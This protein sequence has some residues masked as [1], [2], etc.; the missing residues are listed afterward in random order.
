MSNVKIDQCNITLTR[1]CNLRCS[2]C[3]AKETEYNE[4]NI[5]KYEN[6]KSIIDFCEEAKLK[7][8]VFTGGEPLMYSK[9]LNILKYIKSKSHKMVPTIATNGV[10]L[11]DYDY[12][13]SLID[14]GIEYFDISLKGKD[15]KQC[16][17]IVGTDCF[18]QQMK[19]I[20]NLS[21]FFVEFTCSMVLTWENIDSFHIAVKNAIENGA[22]QFSF[23]LIIDNEK[24][25]LSDLEYLEKY[26]PFDLIKSFISQIDKLN[27]ITSDWWIEYSF[28]ICI[29][30]EEQL[31][32]LEGKLAAPCQIHYKN[33]ITF[34]TNMNILPCNMFIKE[35]I[36]QFN[37]DFSSFKEFKKYTKRD[38]YKY[39][40]ESLSK[41][42]SNE[43]SYCKYFEVCY[44]GC[45]ILWKNY[46]YKS[47]QKFKNNYYVNK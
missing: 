35:K 27:S 11:E 37:R 10:L 13:K 30:T 31:K 17:E 28:P 9:L 39:T 26:N 12:C 36:G 45:P 43:C 21:S 32:I 5:L 16:Y 18:L 7:Y 2:F 46:S 44:G 3:Y 25:D 19:A 6:L 4:N 15:K 23:T 41:A 24:S 33:A 38:P 47:L 29:Y 14:N 34:D 20:R 8:I 1:N 40:M 22:K 42:P